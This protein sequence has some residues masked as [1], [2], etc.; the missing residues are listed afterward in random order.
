MPAMLSRPEGWL[1]R[2]LDGWIRRRAR[3]EPPLTI[4]Y[5][6]VFILPTQ[7][8][9]LLGLLMFGMLMGSLNFNN[10]LGLL[11]AFIVAGLASNSTLL[12][13]R[14]LRGLQIRRCTA[15]P[16]FAG[17]PALLNIS[18]INPEQRE[19]SALEI[20]HEG[21]LERFRI[22]PGETAEVA[23]PVSTRHRGWLTLDRLRLQT[24]YPLGL[25]EAWSWFWPERAILVWPRPAALPP[26]LPQGGGDDQGS[27]PLP[28]P[29]GDSFYS[30][31]PWRAGDSLH[32]VA[33]KASQHHQTLLSREFRTE[34]ARQ[35]VLDLQQAPGRDLEERIS[36]LTAWVLMAER[37]GRVWSLEAGSQRLG[38]GQGESFRIECLRMLAEL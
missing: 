13:Y 11:T 8:G 10:N 38:P 27:Q 3:A 5:R 29:D 1:K 15:Q 37:E 19:R 12:A 21:G 4:A 33:W 9:W 17:T 23:V 28:Q 22:G 16:V 6:Q 7:F 32:R 34:Q 20:R 30:L 24:G 31:R 35:L 2:R 36:I 25:F 18:F 14:N 26:P